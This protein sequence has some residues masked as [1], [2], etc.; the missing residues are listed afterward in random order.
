M[1]ATYIS[2]FGFVIV[3]AN[4]IVFF[5]DFS[6]KER[7]LWLHIVFYLAMFISGIVALVGNPQHLEE[8][9]K[10]LTLT[11]GKLYTIQDAPNHNA[12]YPSNS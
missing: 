1:A 2:I 5:T 11:A 6:Q 3:V 12:N 9:T 8:M 4:T 10:M 7:I